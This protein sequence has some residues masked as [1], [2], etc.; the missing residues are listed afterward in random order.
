MIRKL[1]VLLSTILPSFTILDSNGNPYLTRYYFFGKDRWLCNIYLHHFHQ[2]DNDTGPSGSLLLHMHPWSGL[3]FILLGGY[4]EERRV[5]EVWNYVLRRTVKPLTFNF[6]S[7]NTYHR[8]DL[9][10][11]DAW[12]IF[13]TGS[14]S[15]K[16]DWFF[17]DRE[18]NEKI[19]WRKKVGAIA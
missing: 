13:I 4:E 3:S 17:W 14:R 7:Y 18:T 10:E 15:K 12:S 8:V 16:R 5:S 9:L 2:S 19:D 6:I 1:C 11:K